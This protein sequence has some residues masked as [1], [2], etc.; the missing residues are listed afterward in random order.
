MIGNCPVTDTLILPAPAK[1]NLFLHIN[2][3]RSNGYHELQTIFQFLDYSDTLMFTKTDDNQIT[4]SCDLS[5]L[6]SDDNLIIRAARLLQAN[7]AKDKGI[8][9]HLDKVLPMGGGV[10]G[11]SSDAATTMLALNKLW[12]LNLSP[13]LLAQLGL[14]LGADIPVFINGHSVFAQGVG[15]LFT[16]YQPAECWYLVAKPNCHVATDKIF[17]HPDLPRDTPTINPQDYQFDNSMND[18]QSLVK[19]LYPEV[20]KTLERLIEYAPTRMTG[21]GACIFST[22]TNRQQAEK[23]A[24]KAKAYLPKNVSIFIAKGLNVSPT[25]TALS[26]Y[27]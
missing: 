7:Y 6:Q 21:T 19:K 5:E 22:F 23:T 26:K 13:A 15:E 8:H 17:K 1:I 10:G 18:C 2:G 20:A 24:E 9:I 4:L 3:Q 11:G 14:E 25:H 12:E 16:P 27:G